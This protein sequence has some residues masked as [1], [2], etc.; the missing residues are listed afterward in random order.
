[1]EPPQ[2]HVVVGQVTG[3]WGI[4]GHVKVQ[5]QT[6]LSE[7]FD[8]GSTL[9]V[10]GILTRVASMRPNK[11]G[12]VVLLESVPDRNAAESL[13]GA[14]L[15]IPERELLELPENTFYHFQLV[16]MDVFTDEDEYLGRI[17]E[18]IETPGNDVYI[19][20]QP[21]ERDLLLPAIKDV[22]LNV[23]TESSRMTVH[24]LPGLR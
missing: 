5:P 13:R 4:L 3:A 11:G 7:R 12:Y 21:N 19:V 6:A 22:V 17:A 15:T 23:D 8:Q 18:I 20:R 1:M 14:Y 10:D 2:D 16:E 9:Y 24:L